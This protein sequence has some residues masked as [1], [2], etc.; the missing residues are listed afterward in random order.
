MFLIIDKSKK[1]VAT[2]KK[3]WTTTQFIVHQVGD[4]ILITWLSKSPQKCL[5]CEYKSG[6]TLNDAGYIIDS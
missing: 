1:D 2:L 6:H 3:K 4:Y 5:E